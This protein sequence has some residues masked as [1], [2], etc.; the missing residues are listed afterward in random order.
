MLSRLRK[1]VLGWLGI[2]E[3]AGRVVGGQL[4]RLKQH[5]DGRH[6]HTA[7]E[8]ALIQADLEAIRTTLR[9]KGDLV[10][11]ERTSKE[12]RELY[13]RVHTLDEK[14]EKHEHFTDPI[15]C[16]N[17]HTGV[18]TLQLIEEVSN[19]DP[20]MRR[21]IGGGYYC[22]TCQVS[23]YRANGVSWRPSDVAPTAVEPRTDDEPAKTPDGAKVRFSQP[24]RPR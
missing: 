23:F 12:L 19:E 13:G 18:I 21:P 2:E 8:L 15:E 7:G 11:I 14:L 22:P 16:P 6:K 9:S 5:V 20:A 10:V 1:A 24:R 3:A 17:H 4:R